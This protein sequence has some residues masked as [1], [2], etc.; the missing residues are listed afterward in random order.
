MQFDTAVLLFAVCLVGAGVFFY[1]YQKRR[2]KCFIYLAL[3]F[4]LF[5]ILALVYSVLTIIL[6]MAA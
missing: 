1:F 5:T 3:T 6:V 4:T 2:E